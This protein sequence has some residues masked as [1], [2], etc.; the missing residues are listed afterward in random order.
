MV[1][2]FIFNHL[3]QR[4]QIILH[5]GKFH[6]FLPSSPT[7]TKPS[8]PPAQLMVSCNQTRT[9]THYIGNGE[10]F[11]GKKWGRDKKI[12]FLKGNVFT[13]FKGYI[14][15]LSDKN[16]QYKHSECN[17][18][19]LNASFQL[20]MSLWIYPEYAHNTNLIGILQLMTQL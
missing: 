2:A 6:S 10:I 7:K 12:T 11:G 19:R 4:E 3:P 13:V 9:N 5:L 16:W 14:I 1:I 8:C 17:M 18:L 15:T 20:Q